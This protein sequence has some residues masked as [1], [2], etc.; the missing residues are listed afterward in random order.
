MTEVDQIAVPAEEWIKAKGGEDAS[1]Q[2]IGALV[3]DAR[4]RAGNE[5]AEV[6]S[7]WVLISLRDLAAVVPISVAVIVDEGVVR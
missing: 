6:P 2:R 3:N 5:N 1:I 7:D 4:L